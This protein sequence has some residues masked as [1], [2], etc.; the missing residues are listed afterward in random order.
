M[1]DMIQSMIRF[2]WAMSLFGA[3]Q[4]L[5]VMSA[6]GTARSPRQATGA[7]DAVSVAAEE[8][9]GDTLREAYRTGDRWQRDLIDA[10]FGVVDPAVDVSRG[11]VSKTVLR[12]SLAAFRQSAAVLEAALPAASRNV[13]RE[14]GNK[15][16][17][18]ESFQYVD[19]ILGFEDLDLENLGRQVAR[20]E[21]SGAYGKLWL[22]EGLGFTYA[23][24]AW[25]DGEP[26]DLLRLPA[27]GKLPAASL[28]PLHTGMGLALARHLLPDMA[29]APADVVSAALERLRRLCET[30]AR[31]GYALASYEALGLIVRQLAP[32]AVAAVDGALA[33]PGEVERRST[34]WHGVGRGLYFVATQALP[35][36]TGRAIDKARD[37]A[38]D[39][40]ARYNALSGLA[41]AVT[42]VNFR[43]P[44]VLEG[45]LGE[46]RWSGEE[47]AAIADGI[48][49]AA[50]L[51]FD[52]AGREETFEAFLGHRPSGRAGESWTR[53]V[54]GPCDAAVATWSDVKA[55]PGPGAIFHYR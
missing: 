16:E 53:M 1:T 37:E 36:S 24:R 6:V 45:F 50:L 14:L 10:V 41:W 28:V 8:Q 30:N 23:E 49:S 55:G 22:L 15:I 33:T 43:H 51:W 44:E 21:D 42:L 31:D 29:D 32:G 9:L 25:N 18:F 12:G 4:T 7:F 26:R 35:G 40:L 13:W 52:A 3:R 39:D 19:Q 48:A 54:A 17:A 11:L 46:R 2:S 5:E 20:A 27:A 34:F 38:P 47:K